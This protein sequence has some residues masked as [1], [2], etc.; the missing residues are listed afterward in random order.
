MQDLYF[1]LSSWFFYTLLQSSSQDIKA[2]YLTKIL[3]QNYF[4]VYSSM[5]DDLNL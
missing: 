5:I 1:Q 4:S 2:R 3:T